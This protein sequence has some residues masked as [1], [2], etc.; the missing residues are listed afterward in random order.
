[1]VLFTKESFS[2]FNRRNVPLAP[3]PDMESFQVAVNDSKS[4]ALDDEVVYNLFV[5]DL[6]FVTKPAAI[7]GVSSKA[8]SW[9]M[10]K[11]AS[12]IEYDMKLTQDHAIE[13]LRLSL[14]ER[15]PYRLS[16]L[17]VLDILIRFNLSNQLYLVGK[18]S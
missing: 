8:L 14:L 1:M 5:D 3:I 4:M 17:E 15:F 6:Y 18:S 2:H 9:T 11:I 13:K 12:S 16:T 7:E 10:S